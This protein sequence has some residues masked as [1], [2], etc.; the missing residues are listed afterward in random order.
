VFAKGTDPDTAQVQV[1]NKVQQ[2]VSPALAG[3]AARRDRHQINADFLMIVALYDHG[4]A[5]FGGYFR[6]SGQPFQ[7]SAGPGERVGQV[8]VFG[9]Q[10]AMRVWLDPAKMA[11]VKLMPSDVTSAITRRMSRFRPGRWARSQVKGQQLNAVVQPNRGFPRP[12]SSAPS[13]SRR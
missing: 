5:G 6:L 3:A 8:Q 11:A 2:A 9:S 13:S 1:Q 10:Y 12:I 4:A 7:R